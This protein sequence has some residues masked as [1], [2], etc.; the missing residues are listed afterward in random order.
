M[1][2]S[3]HLDG[4]AALAIQ[5]LVHAIGLADRGH[6][7][8]HREATLFHAEADGLD[9]V[10]HLDRELPGLIDLDQRGEDLEA[11]TVLTARF[12]LVIEILR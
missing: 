11:V 12:R 7:I 1:Q 4:E 9:R 10:G 8:L 6:Q 3:D 2:I 5:H